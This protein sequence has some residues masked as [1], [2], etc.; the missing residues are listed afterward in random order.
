MRYPSF[1]SLV[2]NAAPGLLAGCRPYLHARRQMPVGQGGFHVGTLRYPASSPAYAPP[3]FLY[4]YDCGS[5][6]KR[7]VRRAIDELRGVRADGKLDLLVLSHFDRDHICG[8]PHLL[9]AR[10]GFAVDTV[11]LPFV[12]MAER[13][14]AL[15]Q[16]ADETRAWGGHID[17]FFV[18]MV[19]DPVGTLT[20]LGARRIVL[21]RSEGDET[22]LEDEGD[23]DFD[24]SDP[25]RR[26]KR[27][28]RGEASGPI[29][30]ALVRAY[31][32]PQRPA[33]HARR[34]SG[35]AEVI[36]VRNVAAA[37]FDASLCVEWK[38]LPW[39]RRADPAAIRAFRAKVETL[40]GWAAGTFDARVTEPSVRRQMVTKK[41]T[42][43]TRAYREAFGDK[44]LTSLCLYSGPRYPDRTAAVSLMPR[45]PASRLTKISWMGTGDAHLKDS[46]DIAAFRHGYGSDLAEV[47]TYLLPHHG[48]IENS[49]PGDLIVDADLW[50]A[51]AEPIHDWEHP[52]WRLRAAVAAK[53][54]RFR[55]VKSLEATAV[56]E[57]FLVIA[58]A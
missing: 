31:D 45:R 47:V 57:V 39:V 43:L 28:E 33:R 12:D 3:G 4:V 20:G 6:P 23:P 8:T 50:V 40:F 53:H 10:G 19:F 37:V 32:D 36:E 7:H 48:S 26:P 35:E 9:R 24:P 58:G 34:T 21:V 14:A 56:D 27:E 29:K 49:D 41:R 1:Y 18:N 38:L 52:H 15:A 22:P 54:A 13:I 55:Q 11:M 51:A 25:D 44:N 46:A 30:L 2:A 5:E 16:A 42:R 17:S